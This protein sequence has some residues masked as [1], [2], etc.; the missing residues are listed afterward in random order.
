M[1]L[2][3]Q[4]SE[5]YGAKR[6]AESI[7]PKRSP[8]SRLGETCSPVVVPKF[9]LKDCNTFFAIG[10]CFARN[11]EEYLIRRGLSVL[12]REISF[13]SDELYPGSRPNDLMV[14]Y[15]PASILAE[16]E[17]AF[18][19][20]KMVVE[21]DTP[22][23]DGRGKFFDP[24]MPATFPGVSYDRCV[25]RRRQ[26]REAFSK[27]A[28][29]DAVILTLG[30]IEDWYDLQLG[31]Y[32]NSAP[33][34][35]MVKKHPHR[36]TFRILSFE[37]NL[38][39]VRQSLDL[40]HSVNPSA[41]IVITT[42]PVPLGRT[43]TDRDVIVANT[44]SKSMLRVVAQVS[45][46]ERDYVDY[47]PSYEIVMLS[48]KESAWEDDQRHVLDSKVAEIMRTFMAHY[49]GEEVDATAG[50]LEEAK[51]AKETGNFE[52]AF[53]KYNQIEAHFAKDSAVLSD[54]CDVAL[55]LR[56]FEDVVRLG[57]AVL[58]I[59]PNHGRAGLMVAQ[60][61]VTLHRLDEA[62][63]IS[64]QQAAFPM[65]EIRAR[66]WLMEIAKVRGDRDEATRQADII[67]SL[68]ADGVGMLPDAILTRV[69]KFASVAPS[70]KI[71]S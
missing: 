34:A 10:S 67:L 22:I 60:A 5:I 30:L 19:K 28:H 8:T 52:V 65:Q 13:P 35:Y 54:F 33:T 7:W 58:E 6:A 53:E 69:Q 44:Y 50:L 31:L 14:K 36:F 26:V 25:E 15:T 9:N 24:Y 27:L 49:L 70:I 16:L 45:A 48:D 12:S 1:A 47:F 62:E 3:I 4:A 46:D 18:L 40:I 55:R 43:F 66:R 32:M 57:R 21:E 59:A 42:S 56:K 51:R 29:V 39:F 37:E 2:E 41:K 23:D 63:S 20:E 71:A 38:S 17:G 68:I 64:R 11:I 61:L